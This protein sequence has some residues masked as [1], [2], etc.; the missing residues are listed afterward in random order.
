MVAAEELVLTPGAGGALSLL[1]LIP[2]VP[3]AAAAVNLFVGRRL[4]RWSGWLATAAVAPIASPT[5]SGGGWG[6][7]VS[8]VR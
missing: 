8:D 5:G 6:G 4:G 2:L 3:L 7:R 1:W